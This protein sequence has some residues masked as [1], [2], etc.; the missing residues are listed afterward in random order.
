MV[1]QRLN[2][3]VAM[4][5]GV[6]MA[7]F[8][9]FGVFMWLQVLNLNR[10]PPFEEKRN[11]IRRYAAAYILDASE[12][13]VQYEAVLPH[14]LQ[15]RKLNPEQSNSHAWRKACGSVS[16]P[17][18]DHLLTRHANFSGATTSGVE[19]VHTSHELYFNK[20]RG[21]LS[22]THENNELKIRHDV[23]PAETH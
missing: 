15:E 18:L 7:E 12:L 10:L 22:N 21:L 6:I 4:A 16:R 17:C 13:E 9:E 19:H 1:F 20:R 5:T 23:R 3:L 8:P 11:N 14:A 2:A